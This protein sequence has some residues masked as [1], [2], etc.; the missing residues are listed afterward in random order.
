MLHPGAFCRV[1]SP[2]EKIG[3]S[4]TTHL[5]FLEAQDKQTEPAMGL[6]ELE[7]T[8]AARSDGGHHEQAIGQLAEEDREQSLVLDSEQGAD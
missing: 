7:P 8:E 4:S 3:L 5:P 6:P 2:P 1:H